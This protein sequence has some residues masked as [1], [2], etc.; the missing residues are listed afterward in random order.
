MPDFLISAINSKHDFLKKDDEHIHRRV[1]PIFTANRF[2]RGYGNG[3][4]P[5]NNRADSPFFK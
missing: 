1:L 2:L 3:C 5:M 4:R